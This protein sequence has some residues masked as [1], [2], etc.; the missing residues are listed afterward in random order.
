MAGRWS[1]SEYFFGGS[2]SFWRVGGVRE[3]ARESE[4]ERAR[5]RERE[6]ERA[7]VGGLVGGAVVFKRKVEGGAAD[8]KPAKKLAPFLNPPKR[9]LTR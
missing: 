1:L 8:K 7:R 3:R 2:V 9:F 4:R 5:E 6:R